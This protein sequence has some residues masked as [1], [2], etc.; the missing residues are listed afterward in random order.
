LERLESIV[1]HDADKTR[2][3][4]FLASAR[5]DL[6]RSE[7]QRHIREGLVRVTGVVIRRTAHRVR[8]SDLVSWDIPETKLLS[9]QVIP[10]R[11]LY[12]DEELVAIDKPVGLVVHPGAG[13]TETT[14]VEGLLA[15]R[16]LPESDDP[17]RPGV[18]HRLDKETSG[19]IVVAKT[20][21][22]L[23][24]LQRQFAARSVLKAYVA[25]VEG[26]I[27]EEEGRIDAPVDRDPKRP[28]RMAVLP[29]G[30]RAETDFR[31]LRREP[32]GTLLCVYPRTGRT[33]QIRVHFR[34]IGHPVVGDLLYGSRKRHRAESRPEATSESDTGETARPA[35]APTTI[36]MLLHAWRLVIRHP[37]TGEELRL[38]AEVPKEFPPYRYDAVPWSRTTDEA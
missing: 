1:G 36:R 27:E 28:S 6:S 34:Y 26:T 29:S 3:D 32:D 16:R 19:V 25:V 21:A 22:A 30:R 24:A 17:T 31:V 4:L 2:L 23:E 11:I 33:H 37:T 15:S 12:E 9:P 38:Q 8:T 13:T 35:P 5:P 14:L 18:V 7:I 20:A 10:L